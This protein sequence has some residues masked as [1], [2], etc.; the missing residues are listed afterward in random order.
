MSKAPAERF[1]FESKGQLEVGFDSDIVLV[2]INN[3]YTI[4]KNEFFS[5][6]KNTPFHGWEVYGKV[7]ATFVEGKLAYKEEK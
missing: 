6:G 5:M 3:K 7:K 4:D 2:D 1:G